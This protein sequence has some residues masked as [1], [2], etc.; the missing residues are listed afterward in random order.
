LLCVLV[1]QA[2]LARHS[3]AERI[4]LGVTMAAF[5]PF[6]GWRIM[7]NW[8]VMRPGPLVRSMV[9][10]HP[11]LLLADALP[12]LI[13]QV[14]M[15]PKQPLATPELFRE[16]FMMDATPIDVAAKYHVSAL[17]NTASAFGSP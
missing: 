14:L 13:G 8:A 11:L 17:R 9:G 7:K 16:A 1:D 10:I 5:P 15:D 6:P 12:C 2:Y 4:P 3:R